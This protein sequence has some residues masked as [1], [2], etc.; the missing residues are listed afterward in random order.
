V[1]HNQCI[2][3]PVDQWAGY[4][5]MRRYEKGSEGMKRQKRAEEG[6]RREKSLKKAPPALSHI[7]CLLHPS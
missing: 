5:L 7:S 2:R 6:K 1:I 3:K 4:L